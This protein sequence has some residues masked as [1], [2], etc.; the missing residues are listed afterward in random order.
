MNVDSFGRAQVILSLES[1]RPFGQRQTA[2]GPDGP[3][4]F[5]MAGARRQRWEH[6]SWAQGLDMAGWEMVCIS[7]EE[8]T[9][10]IKA[11]GWDLVLKSFCF[12]TVVPHLLIRPVFAV[13][14]AVTE[15][16]FLQAL[17]AARAS[18][19]CGAM[20]GSCAM[21]LIGAVAAVGVSITPQGVGHALTAKTAVLVNRTGHHT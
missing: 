4:F 1:S 18:E 6:C 17:V 12:T 16:L 9:H 7:W 3:D 15:P 5:L 14:L 11:H 21:R 20:W 10:G 19:L 8:R 2:A 13:V